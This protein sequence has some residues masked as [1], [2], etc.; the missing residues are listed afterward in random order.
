VL[1]LPPLRGFSGDIPLVPLLNL[2]V[3]PP[4]VVF[5]LIVAVLGGLERELDVDAA[6]RGAE[7]YVWDG[8]A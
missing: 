4:D 2:G 7:L 8:E 5:F 6:V 3:I 1:P